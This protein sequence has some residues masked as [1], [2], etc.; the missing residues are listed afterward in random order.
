MFLAPTNFCKDRI[1]TLSQT[2][3][4][5]DFDCLLLC[6]YKY[7]HNLRRGEKTIKTLNNSFHSQ[8]EARKAIYTHVQ[9][10]SEQKLG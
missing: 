5:S 9:Q 4:D 6:F 3:R 1:T 7:V 10:S 2:I 8:R